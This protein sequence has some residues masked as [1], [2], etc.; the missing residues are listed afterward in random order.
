MH[1]GYKS[2]H[3]ELII[4]MLNLGY[5]TLVVIEEKDLKI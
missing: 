4:I 1:I 5:L 3:A 2:L